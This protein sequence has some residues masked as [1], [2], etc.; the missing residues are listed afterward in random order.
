[1]GRGQLVDLMI[2][3]PGRAVANLFVGHDETAVAS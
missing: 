3:I 2:Q 1:M